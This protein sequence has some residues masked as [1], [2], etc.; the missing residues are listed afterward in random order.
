MYSIIFKLKASKLMKLFKIQ[1]RQGVNLTSDVQLIRLIHSLRYG[2]ADYSPCQRPLLNIRSISRFTGVS[3]TTIVKILKS[4][5]KSSGAIQLKG[6]KVYR[7][8]QSQHINFLISDETLRNQAHLTLH[9]RCVM[10]HRRFPEI[11][12]SASSLQKLYKRHKIKFKLINK[13]KPHINFLND[14]FKT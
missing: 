12:L 7:K 13:V 9:Q 14:P 2:S 11:K 4:S 3:E 10:L 6:I 1:M 8:L 5:P